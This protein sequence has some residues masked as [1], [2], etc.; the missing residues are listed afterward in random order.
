MAYDKKKIYKQALEAAQD[1]KLINIKEI[2]A[3]LPIHMSTYYEFF[4]NESEESETIK[5]ILDENKTYRK[6]A[7]RTKWEKGKNATLQLAA[8]KLMADPEELEALQMN[9]VDHRSKGESINI[10]PISWVN[11]D[12]KTE[13]TKDAKNK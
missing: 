1:G 12:E 3:R 11:T 6:A 13:Q 4:P 7:M 5:T 10:A 2:V 9:V 8:Y